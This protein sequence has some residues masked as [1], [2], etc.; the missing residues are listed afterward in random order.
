MATPVQNTQHLDWLNK[1]CS[2]VWQPPSRASH[3]QNPNP[4]TLHLSGI[5]Y[6][7]TSGLHRTQWEPSRG[8][9]SCQSTC[10]SPCTKAHA[11][12]L[13]ERLP[14][15]Y[16]NTSSSYF[17]HNKFGEQFPRHQHIRRRKLRGLR[18]LKKSRHRQNGK[19]RKMTPKGETPKLQN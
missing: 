9:R 5:S 2:D 11:L 16:C 17:K 12:H 6:L 10:W 13:E 3:R 8:V 1:H 19:K 4:G 18:K 14:G 15:F 7:V